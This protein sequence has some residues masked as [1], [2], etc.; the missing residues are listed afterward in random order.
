MD[1]LPSAPYLSAF[2]QAFF[3]ENCRNITFFS[4]KKENIDLLGNL[5]HFMVH[6]VSKYSQIA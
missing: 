2:F 1:I 5:G 4:K 6:K 3:Y